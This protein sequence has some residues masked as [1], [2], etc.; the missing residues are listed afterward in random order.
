M[1]TR[2]TV[3]RRLKRN[4]KWAD[5]HNPEVSISSH[6]ALTLALDLALHRLT[7]LGSLSKD[8]GYGNDNVTKQEYHWLKKEKIIVLHE[9]HKFPC[10]SLSYFTEEQRG[11]RSHD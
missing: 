6:L 11:M 8:D 2:P 5:T 4:V 10:I 1:R 3:R 9:Q 7:P